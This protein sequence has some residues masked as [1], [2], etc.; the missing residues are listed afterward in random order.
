[1][2]KIFLIILAT[3]ISLLAFC[4]IKISIDSVAN[5]YGETVMVCSKVYGTKLIALS[6]TT[7]IYLGAE[8]PNSLLTV[9]IFSKD[10]SNFKDA[11]EVV[12]ADKTVCVTGTLKEDNGK[13]EI[14]A[15]KPD[16]IIIQ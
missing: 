6:Q 13:P 9:V 14:I 1:M 2:K 11:P 4:Q 3:L 5:H 7:F 12:Y 15:S 8:Y 16:D 10:R